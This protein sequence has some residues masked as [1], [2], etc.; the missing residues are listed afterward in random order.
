MEQLSID[1]IVDVFHQARKIAYSCPTF[2]TDVS[3]MVF[4]LSIDLLLIALFLFA[5]IKDEFREIYE[6]I[7][8]WTDNDLKN[9]TS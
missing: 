4:F 1:N 6:W 9:Q 7:R 5:F 2:R 3:K 8:I